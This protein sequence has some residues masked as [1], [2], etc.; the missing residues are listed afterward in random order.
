MVSI[1]TLR[2]LE[3][4]EALEALEGL[5]IRTETPF[6]SLSLRLCRMSILLVTVST[7]TVLER[8]LADVTP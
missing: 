4:L 2:R 7:S 3:P 8:L 5:F 1:P 6:F